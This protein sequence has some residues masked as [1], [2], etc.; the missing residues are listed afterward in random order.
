LPPDVLLQKVIGV[1]RHR[2]LVVHALR[3]R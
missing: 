1:R 2:V 3:T